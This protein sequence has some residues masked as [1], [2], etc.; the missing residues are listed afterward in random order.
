MERSGS[1]LVRS[2]RFGSSSSITV[3]KNP[4]LFSYFDAA[5]LLTI[6]AAY[7]YFVGYVYH[8]AYYRYFGVD[9]AF[10]PRAGA[11]YIM[12]A[13]EYAFWSIFSVFVLS[14]LWGALSEPLPPDRVAKIKAS[15][16]RFIRALVAIVVLVIMLFAAA[17]MDK[18]GTRDAKAEADKKNV[19]RIFTT[20]NIDLPKE[21]Y[22]LS[23][24]QGKYLLY[25]FPTPYVR[26]NVIVV[27]DSS[28]AKIEF[29]RVTATEDSRR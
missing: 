9:L 29:P 2:P 19:V 18:R 13:W 22:L 20:T 23:Y 3:M 1:S 7:M 11:D 24:S 17:A 21:V 26:P 5:A 6:V 8:V 25:Y 16:P 12:T 14:F 10:F 27:N 15:M 4:R 28:V